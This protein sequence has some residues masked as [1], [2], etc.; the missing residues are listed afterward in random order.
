[1]G[2]QA[3]VY[4]TC[5][6][7]RAAHW[8][9]GQNMLLPKTTNQHACNSNINLKD[10]KRVVQKPMGDV[11]DGLHLVKPHSALQQHGSIAKVWVLN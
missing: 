1:M 5:F 2:G 11:I 9:S 3:G 6:L 10:S 4:V 7:V 8:S